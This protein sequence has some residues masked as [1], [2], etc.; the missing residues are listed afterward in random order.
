MVLE[1]QAGAVMRHFIVGLYDLEGMPP[2]Q[3]GKRLI[4]RGLVYLAAWLLLMLCIA[5]F[6]GFLARPEPMP[7][8][9]PAIKGPTVKLIE[10]KR[11]GLDL[12]LRILVVVFTL[13][14]VG[15]VF[16]GGFSS[17]MIASGIFERM[18]D[19]PVGEINNWFSQLVWYAKVGVFPL[20]LAAVTLVI[21]MPLFVL[22]ALGAGVEWILGY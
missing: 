17:L 7:D 4:A 6:I 20:L 12:G 14:I 18:T 3:H 22:V 10:G 5:L 21:G 8:I 19:V 9:G 13:V 11:G 1:G 2:C 16:W 15:L